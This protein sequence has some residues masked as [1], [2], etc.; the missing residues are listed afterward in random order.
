[1]PL[2]S[3]RAPA[4]LVALLACVL[5]FGLLAWQLLARG[6]LNQV[7]QQVTLWLAA[8]RQPAL[9][10]AMLLVSTVHETGFLLGATALLAGWFGWRHH[11]R[12]VP[13]LLVVPTGMLLNVLLKDGFQRARPVLELPLVHYATYSFPSGHATGST[14]FY[15]ALCAVVFTRTR[16]HGKRTAAVAGAM[17]M[18]LLVCFSRVY[19][20]AHYLTDVSAGVSVGLAWLLAWTWMFPPV[21]A[22]R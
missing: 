12:W 21:A 11:P 1:M 8:R 9:T 20:G 19:L 4:R 17:A 10:Q 6:A 13:M 15:G 22:T 18:V 2:Q 5:V 7:D 16:S 14:V 3:G